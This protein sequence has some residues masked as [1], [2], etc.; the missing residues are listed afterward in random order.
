MNRHI[1]MAIF[2]VSIM[3]GLNISAGVGFPDAPHTFTQGMDSY[4]ITIL[5]AV[6]PLILGYLGG[7]EEK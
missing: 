6:P 4:L 5:N 7:K 1:F 3:G 2:Y